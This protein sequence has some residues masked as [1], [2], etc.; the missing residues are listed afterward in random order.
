MD[1]ISKTP[2]AE[3]SKQLS[4]WKANPH[5]PSKFG[6]GEKEIKQ[7]F[8]PSLL[9]CFQLHLDSASRSRTQGLLHLHLCGRL[10][11]LQKAS[12]EN[13]AWAISLQQGPLVM[14]TAVKFAPRPCCRG[15][16][17]PRA[18]RK[19]HVA[20]THRQAGPPYLPKQIAKEY[21]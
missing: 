17:F 10:P 19:D 13:N 12:A 5:I 8:L 11:V 6:N 9:F 1:Y 20:V 21:L 16:C 2:G 18:E 14:K 3:K 15:K 4:L 7:Y